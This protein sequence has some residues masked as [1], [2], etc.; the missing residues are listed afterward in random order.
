MLSFR[1]VHLDFHTEGSIN[2]IGTRFSKR[3]FKAALQRGHVGSVTLFAKCHHGWS[4]HPTKA[5]QI[6]PN[7][8]FDLLAR[9]I[10]A[11]R[12]IGVRYRIYLSAGVDE[13][14]AMDHP[15]W[16]VKRRDGVT[17]RPLEAVWFKHLRFNSPYLEVLCDQIR[18]VVKRWND[19]EG[20]FLDIIAP[21]HDY[22]EGALREMRSLDLN[23]DKETDVEIYAQHVLT[24]YHEQTNAAARSGGQKTFSVFHNAGHVPI[25][26]RRYNGYNGHLELESLPTG[27]WGYDHFGIS[28][29]YAITTGMDYLGMTGKFHTTWGE[30]GGFKRSAAL[31]YECSAMLAY[32]AKCSVG[33][34][35]HPDGAMNEDT[36]GLIGAAYAEV[37]AK[38]AWC[39]GVTA[40]TRIALVSAERNQAAARSH[41]TASVADEG[42]SRMLMELHLPFLVLDHKS[43][44][45]GFDL[46]I[47]PEGFEMNDEIVKRA[48]RFLKSGGRIIAAGGALI[49]PAG[50]RFALNPGARLVGRSPADPDYLVATSATPHVSVKT[51]I[52]IHGGCYEIE[53]THG[54]RFIERRVTYFNRTW[55]HF[56]SHQHAPDASTPATPAA[57]ATDQI[58]YFSHDLFTRYARY[59]QPLYRDF[60]LAALHRLLGQ[61]LPVST[62]LPT[63]GRFNLLEQ[64]NQKRFIAHLLYAPKSRRGSTDIAGQGTHKPIEIIEDLVPLFGVRIKLRLP[65]RIRTARLVPSG[66]S[67]TFTQTDGV[68]AFTVPEFVAHQMVELAY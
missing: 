35:L 9:Q 46:V 65:R 53:P 37:E 41:L 44:W 31:R 5:G 45:A 11:C 58:V 62:S 36:Y 48:G 12:E 40:V 26:A 64:K 43:P 21:Q 33:D 47:L 16:V 15:D 51:P 20:L 52:V 38:E 22:S 67:L 63:D 10:E 25:G 1:Q 24:R 57:V 29:R 60:F 54:Q 34:Q 18:E 39:D 68:V 2:Q 59:G 27:G 3:D 13:R 7:L 49:D 14:L 30:F 55:R 66:E 61:E 19:C 8:G 4:Y 6:H 28:A 32:G 56:C 50:N 17:Y 42:A 23:A